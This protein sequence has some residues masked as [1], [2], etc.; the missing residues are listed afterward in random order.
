MDQRSDEGRDAY[1]AYLAE[2]GLDEMA[3][4]P[5]VAR[6]GGDQA[7]A[8]LMAQL[9]SALGDEALATRIGSAL[10]AS[11]N[12]LLELIDRDLRDRLLKSDL[13]PPSRVYAGVFPTNTLNAHAVRRSDWNLVLLNTGTFEFLEAVL[14]LF[15]SVAPG[16]AKLRAQDV[17]RLV[18][19]YC[20]G[21]GLEERGDQLAPRL[22]GDRGKAVQA[23]LTSCEQFVLAHEYGHIAKGHLG[24]HTVAM[25][26]PRLG[27]IDVL[28]K[29]KDQEFEAD[30]W[31]ANALVR[32]Y[33]ADES[34]S[35]AAV[36]ACVG[37]LMF[38]LLANVIE[39][40]GR[41]NGSFTDTHPP[42]WDRYVALRYG[43]AKA[44][45]NDAVAMASDFAK[46]CHL[47]GADLGIEILYE[48]ST[49]L[50]SDHV[51]ALVGDGLQ[52]PMPLDRQS[53]V[54]AQGSGEQ[55]A[56]AS[57]WGRLFGSDRKHD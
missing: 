14:A 3:V 22:T 6:D 5:V 28:A 57:I 43:Y 13:T 1:R 54:M 26:L 45:L 36:V 47:V 25:A 46:F 40:L 21:E 7:S 35:G 23:F 33:R 39:Q 4:Q 20:S 15:L 10:N 48:D 55:T 19:A 2:N 49:L 16:E 50:I 12:D 51:G 9:A 17:A 18:E 29:S 52:A 38:L 56:P 37:P 8:Q 30:L 11:T 32:I 44:G 53:S 42:A 27:A 31:A 41:S 24:P 34:E